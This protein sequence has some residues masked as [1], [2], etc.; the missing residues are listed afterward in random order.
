MSADMTRASL[1]IDRLLFKRVLL[2]LTEIAGED[3][4]STN[5]LLDLMLI[6]LTI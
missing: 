3:A 1:V 6:M 4:F 2:L 5:S